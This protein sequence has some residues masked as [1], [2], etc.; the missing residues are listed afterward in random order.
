MQLSAFA[1]GSVTLAWNPSADPAVAGYYIYYG[2]ASD[3]YTNEVFAGN[4]TNTTISGLVPGAT[5]YFAATTY[6]LAGMQSSFS[7]EVSYQVPA[8]A[9][10]GNQPP[11]LNIIN[12]LSLNENAGLQTVTLSGITSG[13]TN[14]NPTVTITAASS[15]TNLVPNPTVNYTNA[16]PAGNLTL[17]P[18]TNA[19]GTVTI[20]VTVNNGAITNNLVTQSFNVTVSAVNQLPTLN[21][22]GNLTLNENAGLQTVP[23]S[24]ITSGA[25]NES[26]VL[27]VTAASSNTNLVPNLSVNYVSANPTGNLTFTPAANASGTATITVTVNDHGASNNLVTRNFT[28]TVNA[29]GVASTNTPTLDP[30][31]NLVLTNWSGPQAVLLTGISPG[32]GAGSQNL[33]VTASASD[34]HHLIFRPR[35]SYTS[36][37]ARGALMIRPNHGYGTVTVT[38][39]VDNGAVSNNLVTRSFT[40]TVSPDPKPASLAPAISGATSS[41]GKTKGN[42]GAVAAIL[43]P[44]VH[45][46]GQYALT[47]AGATGHS[48]AVEASTDLVNWV[49]V[50]TNKAPFTYVD[51]DAGKFPQRFYRVVPV[52]FP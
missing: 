47:V 52:S 45:A 14:G 27:A 4:A 24:G 46:R 34:S 37:A 30:I 10:P 23:L 33:K 19:Y 49:A 26:Q 20:T 32:T 38:V 51:P 40:V 35:V 17:M 21:A 31:N 50:Q 8:D 48:Y 42:T 1:A 15:D 28:V 7:T 16:S 18:A 9:L 3:T 22:I 5:Y 36:P 43:T 2:G 12:N 29:L 39:T 44:A 11:T 6:N 25:A 13:L 41:A